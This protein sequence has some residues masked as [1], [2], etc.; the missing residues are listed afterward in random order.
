MNGYTENAASG[1]PEKPER[2]EQPLTLEVARRMLPLVRR[3]VDDILSHRQRLAE[4]IPEQERLDRERRNLAWP[5]RLRRYRLRD[6][7]A[8]V[9][10]DLLD[11]RAELEVLGLELVDLDA[12]QLGFP[13]LVNERAAFFSWK[14]G[15]EEISY[16]HYADETLR[17]RIPAS[18]SRT[19]E[20]VGR[21]W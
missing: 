16:W 5:N 3:V 4:L 7:I 21:E 8:G 15:E 11:A 2:R 19:P 9:E 17:R 6:E 10:H 20:R 1:A 12:G 14:R 18:W 13:T